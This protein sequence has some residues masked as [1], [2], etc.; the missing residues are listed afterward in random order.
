VYSDPPN[1]V[2]PA[3]LLTFSREGGHFGFSRPLSDLL[4]ELSMEVSNRYYIFRKQVFQ[5]EKLENLEAA[6]YNVPS[7]SRN[8]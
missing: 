2:L 7:L 3:P 4:V 5:P 8:S 6:V 1:Y